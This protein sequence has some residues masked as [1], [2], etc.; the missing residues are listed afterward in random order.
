[1]ASMNPTD[2][3]NMINSAIAH[4]PRGRSPTR[5]NISDEIIPTGRAPRGTSED[6]GGENNPN[7]DNY[8]NY[9]EE[10]NTFID[11]GNGEEDPEEDPEDAWWSSDPYGRW[12]PAA[13]G[14]NV[15][16]LRYRE[17]DEVQVPAFPSGHGVTQWRMSIAKALSIMSGRYDYEEI[18]WFICEGFGPGITFESL[19]DSGPAR[20]KSIDMKL[21]VALGKIIKNANNALTVDLGT[22]EEKLID[23]GKML[24]GR[25]IAWKVIMFYQTNPICDLTFG[26]SDLIEL[27]WQG[28]SGVANFI[29]CWRTILRKMR[30]RLSEDELGEVLYRKIKHSKMMLSD[31]AHYERQVLNHPDR[32]YQYLL[33][34]MDRRIADAQM[35]RNRANDKAAIRSGNVSGFGKNVAAPA[36]GANNPPGKKA[37]AKA[38]AKQA[39]ALAASTTAEV[40][41]RVALALAAHK[42]KGKGKGAGSPGGKGDGKGKG[43]DFKQTPCWFFNCHPNGCTKSAEDCTHKHGK[44]LSKVEADK[45]VKPGSTPGTG[46]GS[47]APSPGKGGGKGGGKAPKQPVDEWCKK[48]LAGTC[49]DDNCT[50]IH[51]E[52]DV[53]KVILEKR[54]VAAAKAKAKAKP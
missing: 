11:A 44:K 25:Q 31:I 46:S 9:E 39:K 22:I 35:E 1:L 32:S 17:K 28:D 47:R 36:P 45:L 5:F 24:M 29:T 43:K 19:A 38:A 48:Y 10:L 8:D 2:V 52:P 3:M 34:C 50:R 54:K 4:L 30:T 26:V 16:I 27:P 49:K 51:L 42:G 13:N 53:V 7:G 41:S 37:Q 6:F 23:E 40:D 21:S 18:N 33:N 15:G 12:Q 20:Y 14:T